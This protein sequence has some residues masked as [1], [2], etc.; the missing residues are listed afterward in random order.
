MLVR[1][2]NIVTMGTASRFKLC[3]KT[4]WQRTSE[5]RTGHAPLHYA[6]HTRA[7]E[8]ASHQHRDEEEV[9]RQPVH[10][11]LTAASSGHV[12]TVRSCSS[13]GAAC[14]DGIRSGPA[15]HVLRTCISNRSNLTMSGKI[16]FASTTSMTAM[17]FCNGRECP[18]GVNV[19]GA[20]AHAAAREAMQGIRYS[21]AL[22]HT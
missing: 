10:R 15:V 19:R 2:L 22:D 8:E 5:H 18:H 4:A 6:S 11:H 16:F 9:D 17:P 20:C 12:S 1:F 21:I 7:P 14:M 13:P 3:R